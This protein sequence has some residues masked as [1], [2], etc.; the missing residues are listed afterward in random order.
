MTDNISQ[1][2][3]IQPTP[4]KK[5]DSGLAVA[6]AWNYVVPFAV[7]LIGTQLESYAVDADGKTIGETYAAIYCLKII[8]VVIA[9]GFCRKSLAD[10]VPIPTAKVIVVAILTGAFVTAFWIGLDGLYPGLPESMGKRSAFDPTSLG[11][12]WRTLFMIFRGLG[13]VV[14]VPIIEE[15]FTRDFLLRFVSGTDWQAIPAWKFN[16]TAAFVSTAIFVSGHP[17]WLPALLCGMLWI[18][19][20]GWSKSVSAVVISHAVANL[21]LGLYSV[22]TG[23]WHYL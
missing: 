18:W 14:V 9:L 1:N 10:L 21:G 20:L 11:G 16:T 12:L 15:L 2:D 17:E 6:E 3:S 8:A 4:Q 23:D 5:M 7:F 19:L 13:L 22:I